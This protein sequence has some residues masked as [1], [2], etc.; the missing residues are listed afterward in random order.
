MPNFGMLLRE[1]IKRLARRSTRA[2]FMRLR[3]DSAEMRRR[4]A[5]QRK[6]IEKLQRD[7]ANLMADAAR[8]LTAL[9]HVPEA[10]AGRIRISPRIIRS[11]RKRLGLSRNDFAA[12]IGASPASVFSWESGRA[13]PRLKVKLA[14]AAVRKLGRREAKRKLELLR[15]NGKA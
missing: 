13:K 2:D 12:L 4:V 3:K 14:L 15:G 8:R 5:D 11:Q 7:N 1:E 9:P 6:D 10:E